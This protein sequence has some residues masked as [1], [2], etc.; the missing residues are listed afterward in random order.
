MWI[1]PGSQFNFE[2]I[3]NR[4]TST[5]MSATGETANSEKI[6]VLLLLPGGECGEDARK[7]KALY[8]AAYI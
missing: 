1:S 4:M 2:F 8:K 7:L 6:L 5:C 3:P